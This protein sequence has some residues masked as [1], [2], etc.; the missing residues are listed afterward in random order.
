M[1]HRPCLIKSLLI[2]LCAS[3]IVSVTHAQKTYK[4]TFKDAMVVEFVPPFKQITIDVESEEVTLPINDDSKIV[5]K[6]NKTLKPELVV[7]SAIIDIDYELVGAQRVVTELKYDIDEDGTVKLEGLFERIEKDVAFID[8]HKVKLSG[9]VAIVG[10]KEA[11]CECKGLVAP[12]FSDQFIKPGQFFFE[13]KGK[14]NDQGVIVAEEI[15]ACKNTVLPADAKLRE[16]VENSYNSSGLSMVN[17]PKDL[18][19]QVGLPLHNGNIKIGQYAYKLLDDI[20]IQGYVNSIGERLIPE[21]QK[22]LLSGDG[23]K[24]NF[25][26]YVIDNPIPNAFAFPNGMIFVHT[27]IL[28]IME[29]EAEL[30]VVLGHEIA[31]VTHEHGRENYESTS[32]VSVVGGIGTQLLGRF[33][34]NTG[35]ASGIA[36]SVTQVYSAIRPEGLANVINPQPARES[37]ADRVG[38]Q[39]AYLAGYDIR[40]SV[41]FW[42]KMKRLTNDGNFK[43]KLNDNFKSML[44]SSNFSYGNPLTTLGDAGFGVLAKML[45]ETAYTSHPK[46][47][48][49]AQALNQLILSG[50]KGEDLNTLD[51]GEK[52]FQKYLRGK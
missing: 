7:P 12:S 20:R 6:K 3:L 15:E 39:Y 31:H 5:N 9:G 16:A 19:F 1:I 24:I 52:M 17:T 49:R 46:S 51:K 37:Q 11:K 36:S 14:W 35:L 33:T 4:G 45:L 8:G 47:K 48:A 25:R 42:N 34:R 40:E 41:N 38:L 13:L 22:N 32:I 29:N 27:G 10:K 23:N 50:Y 30:A 26:F 21:H 43:S 2:F 28:D 44:A 18:P